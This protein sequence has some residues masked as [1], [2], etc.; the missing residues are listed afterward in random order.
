[1]GV[2]TVQSPSE[3]EAKPRNGA[4]SPDVWRRASD[5]DSLLSAR[6]A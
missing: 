2:P 6:R 3:G 4:T 5:Y 1:M